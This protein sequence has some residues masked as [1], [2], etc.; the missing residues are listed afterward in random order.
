[1]TTHDRLLPVIG[2]LNVLAVTVAALIVVPKFKLMFDGFGGDLPLAT[3]LMLAT[4]RGWGLAAL[5]VPA[6]WIAWPDRQARGAVALLAG[7]ATAV[8]L[9]GFGIWACYSP[10]FALAAVVG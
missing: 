2:M 10:I 1:M 7:I 5:L 8:V 3:R 4:Y 6:I 9:T